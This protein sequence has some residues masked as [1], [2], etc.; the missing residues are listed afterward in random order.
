MKTAL[1]EYLGRIAARSQK[2]IN[3]GTTGRNLGKA[4]ILASPTHRFAP[5]DT[6]ISGAKQ[7]T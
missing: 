6:D 2:Y 3:D 4:E 1:S 7:K 5:G